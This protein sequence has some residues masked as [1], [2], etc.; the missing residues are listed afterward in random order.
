MAFH[1]L[2]TGLNNELLVEP[3]ETA[4]I[5]I[6]IATSLESAGCHALKVMTPTR[7]IFDRTTFEKLQ[8][9]PIGFTDGDPQVVPRRAICGGG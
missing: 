4:Q 5:A 6:E 7:D 9:E 2:A 3:A 1:V 8:R